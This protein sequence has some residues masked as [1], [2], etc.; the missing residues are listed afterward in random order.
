MKIEEYK[1]EATSELNKTFDKMKEIYEEREFA[2][3]YNL[4]S[5]LFQIFKDYIYGQANKEYQNMGEV[6]KTHNSIESDITLLIEEVFRQ[7][8]M[9]DIEDSYPILKDDF[10][11]VD[12]YNK[13]KKLIS[14][15]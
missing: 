1:N 8:D 4:R 2:L 12:I 11:I 3:K 5:V 7:T 15:C 10:L 14:K 9:K 6:F 13:L